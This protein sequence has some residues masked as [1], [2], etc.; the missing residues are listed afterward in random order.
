[1]RIYEV[2]ALYPAPEGT[3]VQERAVEYSS[4]VANTDEAAIA[5][6]KDRHMKAGLRLKDVEFKVSDFRTVLCPTA[7]T[8]TA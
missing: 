8:E 5:A 2:L 3:P 4:L 6:A 1:M 7:L